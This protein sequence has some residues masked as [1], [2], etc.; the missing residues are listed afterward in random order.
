MFIQKRGRIAIG[1]FSIEAEEKYVDDATVGTGEKKIE[2]V[3]LPTVI[4]N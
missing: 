4:T 1:G 2:L 3:A